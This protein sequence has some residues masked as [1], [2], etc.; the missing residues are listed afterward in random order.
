[1]KNEIDAYFGTYTGLCP[2]DESKIAMGEIKITIDEQQ[3]KIRH[4]T[5][6]TIDENT[7][8]LAEIRK[9]S[10]D[11]LRRQF[12]EGSSTYKR[13]DGFQIGEG[14]ILLFR[15]ET[16]FEKILPWLGQAEPR[17]VVRLNSFVEMLGLTMLYDEKQV[18]NGAI[19]RVVN[20]AAQHVGP[21]PFPRLEY[22]GLHEPKAA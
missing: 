7:V 14:A 17:L 3:L 19:D 4:A 2:T 6:L 1:M 15:R 22:D 18:S 5:G 21:Y 13:V 8:A 12:N 20:H 16:R 9:L 11:E 10:E